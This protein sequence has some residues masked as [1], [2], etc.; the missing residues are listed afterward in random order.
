MEALKAQA[1]AARTYAL[2]SMIGAEARDYDV[3]N[4]IYSQVYGGKNSERYRTGLAV[5]R[6]MGEVLVF[7]GKI[8][9]AYFHATCGGMT[10]DAHELW[11]MDL[12][13]LKG[14]PCQFCQDS[15]HMHWKRNFRL[16]DIQ[17]ALNKHGYKIGLIKDLSVVDRD[18]SG[19]INNL[20]IIDRNEQELVIKGK[21]FREAIGPNDLKSNKFEIE[22]KGYYVDFIGSGWGHGVGLCQWGARG[23]ASQQFNY[24]QI[25]AYYYPGSK[26]TDYHDLQ[27]ASAKPADNLSK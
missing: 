19:R 6:T 7:E 13:P 22:M 5:D 1:V 25:V 14:V 23:M 8:L 9:P 21:D 10:E 27:T 26:L 16:Q 15:P 24:K 18:R 20:K 11:D 2:Y 12:P 17:Q 4:D 3:T